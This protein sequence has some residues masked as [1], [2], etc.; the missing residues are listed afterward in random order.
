[1]A[2]DPAVLFYTSDFL[3]GTS[4]F[5][6]EEKGKYIT[7]L[8]QQHQLGYIPKNHMISVCGSLDN[9]VVDKFI[10]DD[11]EK[12]YNK[13]MRDEAEKRVKYCESRSNNKSGR[14]K[15]EIICESYENHML[16][17]M[18][19][20]NENI[21]ANDKEKINTKTKSINMNIYQKYFYDR[22]AEVMGVKYVASFGKDGKMFKDLGSHLGDEL[23]AL[24]DKYLQETDE[25]VINAG[26][27]VG[28]FKARVNSLRGKKTT[29]VMSSKAQET[30]RNCIN[31]AERKRGLNEKKN[32]EDYDDV[33]GG[34]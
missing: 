22:Y 34:V 9:Q 32:N 33:I 18:E 2:K 17:H 25:F 24:I 21:N 28:V 8:C 26:Y 1:M 19:N 27:S 20:G 15:S 10:T 23:Y 12:Y 6:Y 13:R 11:G 4:F 16:L 31:L 7:L 30:L 5:S 14:K 3:S 29:G